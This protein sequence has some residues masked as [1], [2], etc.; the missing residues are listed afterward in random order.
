M[1]VI[2]HITSKKAWQT[3]VDTYL[4]LDFDQEGF[5]HCSTIAQVLKPANERYHGQTDLVLLCIDEEKVKAPIIYEDCY[6]S[7][8]QFPHIY[9]RLNIDAVQKVIDFPPNPDGSFS[10]PPNFSAP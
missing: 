2:L 6:E 3:A 9:G 7:G 5:I 8:T 4:P 10:L 1:G